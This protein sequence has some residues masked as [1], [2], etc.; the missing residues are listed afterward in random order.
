MRP[1]DVYVDALSHRLDSN[2]AGLSQPGLPRVAPRASFCG[3][4]PLIRQP[5]TDVMGTITLKWR[6]GG[7]PVL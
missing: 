3:V 2:R 6:V 4:D 1:G 7:K 5:F